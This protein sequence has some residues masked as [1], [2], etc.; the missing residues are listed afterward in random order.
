MFVQYSFVPR[1]GQTAELA[2]SF[3][4][5]AMTPAK[6]VMLGIAAMTLVSLA[7]LAG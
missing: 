2:W 3:S 7:Y 5:I 6:T 1:R 4:P